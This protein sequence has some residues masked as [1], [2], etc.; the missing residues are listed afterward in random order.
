M[1]SDDAGDACIDTRLRIP[2]GTTC[3]FEV[4]E[5]PPGRA[6]DIESLNLRLAGYNGDS[7]LDFQL[8]RVPDVQSC[9]GVRRR[10]CRR[11]RLPRT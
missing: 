1:L 2:I 7:P 10:V 4:P 8:E 6:I 11:I 9:T 5:A 3:Y